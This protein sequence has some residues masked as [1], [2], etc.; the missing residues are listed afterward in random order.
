MLL[1]RSVFLLMW[2]ECHINKSS[3][4]EFCMKCILIQWRSVFFSLYGL[5]II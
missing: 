2:S 4:Q 1:E 3:V 5:C